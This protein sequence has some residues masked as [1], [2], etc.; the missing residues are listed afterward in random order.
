M[1]RLIEDLSGKAP[2][3]PRAWVFFSS[4]LPRDLLSGIRADAGL[5]ARL[6]KLAEFNLEYL[7]VDQHAFVT[8]H[9]AALEHLFGEPTDGGA[10]Y[11]ATI[12]SI[13]ARLATLFGGLKEFPAIRYRKA[14][15]EGG[16]V[17]G[18]D[19]VPTQLAS[20]LWDRI[21]R[22]KQSLPGFPAAE[23]CDL[24]IVDRSVDPVRPRTLA[25]AH[26]SE[27]APP[28]QA[29]VVDAFEAGVNAVR[30]W[31]CIVIEQRRIE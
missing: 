13:A 27:K 6:G 7:A 12:E 17:S 3:Y 29:G 14:R 24:L 11:K 9:P 23:T 15:A 18:R 16:A 30:L 20:A 8:D 21:F 1:K 4:P 31:T 10:Q 22:L 28:R 19:L 5:V 25:L 26:S 2:L